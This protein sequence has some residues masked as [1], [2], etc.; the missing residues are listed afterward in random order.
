MRQPPHHAQKKVACSWQHI[1]PELEEQQEG[2]TDR[3]RN[4]EN[5]YFD[6]NDFNER[7]YSGSMGRSD[8]GDPKR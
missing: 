2:A 6:F 3:G 4:F 8:I 7:S 1:S 5:I